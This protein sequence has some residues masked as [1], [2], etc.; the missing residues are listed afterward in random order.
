[1]DEF[2][3]YS[4]NPKDYIWSLCIIK[5]AVNQPT[6]CVQEIKKIK[7][8]IFCR[9]DRYICWCK[10]FHW[11]FIWDKFIPKKCRKQ[12]L[13]KNWLGLDFLCWIKD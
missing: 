3:I 13:W 1:M 5:Q 6:R 12:S 8:W 10:V 9:I 11:K 2:E 7:E 4:W